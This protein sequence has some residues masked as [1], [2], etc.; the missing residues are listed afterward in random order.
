MQEQIKSKR[1]KVIWRIYYLQD[2]VNHLY[3]FLVEE[4]FALAYI[5]IK[6]LAYIIIKKHMMMIVKVH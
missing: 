6:N 3:S 1:M 4:F 5:I 2:F